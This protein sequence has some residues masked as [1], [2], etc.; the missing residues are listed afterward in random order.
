MN[1]HKVETILSEDGTLMLQGLPF[2]TGDE[3]EVIILKRS[4]SVSAGETA[5][6]GM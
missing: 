2:H 1:A 6:K 3:V 5:L 4:P